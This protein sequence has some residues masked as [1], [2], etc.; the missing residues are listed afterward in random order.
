MVPLPGSLP[1]GDKAFQRAGPDGAQVKAWAISSQ[2]A[3]LFLEGW[4]HYQEPKCPLRTV[5]SDVV[6]HCCDV[7]SSLVPL[8]SKITSQS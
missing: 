8:S 2:L 5:K 4:H 3:F 6:T 1:G 7:G